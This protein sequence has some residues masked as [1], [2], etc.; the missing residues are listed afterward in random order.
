M[1]FHVQRDFLIK[2]L[3]FLLYFFCVCIFS[4]TSREMMINRQ[5][6]ASN[7]RASP[8]PTYRFRSQGTLLRFVQ[9]FFT[10]SF[11][12]SL[13]LIPRKTSKDDT[14][15]ENRLSSKLELIVNSIENKILRKI[16]KKSIKIFSNT[17]AE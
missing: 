3:F 7:A 12:F 14:S 16:E 10:S 6:Q 9:N 15:E 4:K 1:R 17:T 11:L 5:R 13:S 2:T 8:P